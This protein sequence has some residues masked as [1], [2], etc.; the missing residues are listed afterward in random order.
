MAPASTKA[1]LNPLLN[2]NP[3][4]LQI[5]GICSALAVTKTL[6]TALMMSMAVTA[7]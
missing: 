1:L 5:L 6:A 2:D 3:I 4:T 7:V